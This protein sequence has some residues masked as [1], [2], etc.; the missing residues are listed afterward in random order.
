M[1]APLASS[2]EIV[3]A[4]TEIGLNQDGFLTAGQAAGVN[5][6]GYALARLVKSGLLERD[7]RGLYRLK[8]F[9]RS[10]RAE[11]WRA[12][13]VPGV[14]RSKGIAAVLCD[15]TALSLHSVSTI[16][17]KAVEVSV[18]RSARLRRELPRGLTVYR[19]DY[20]EEDVTR[21]DGLPTTTLFRTLVDLIANRK[22]LQFVAEALNEAPKRLLLTSQESDTLSAMRRLDPRIIRALK[23]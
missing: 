14:Q 21:I 16:N 8:P 23:A 13:L 22:E 12:V 6:D 3:D 15:G 17:P 1:T 18:P 5:I 4:L 20:P 10:E 2:S 11:L 7:G 9:P 19:R